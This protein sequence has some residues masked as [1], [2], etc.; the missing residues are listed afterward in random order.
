[1]KR[2]LIVLGL[3]AAHNAHAQSVRMQLTGGE[4]YAGLPFGLAIVADG[5]DE[6]PQPAQPTLAIPGATVTPLGVQPN[7]ST[8][9]QIF[10]GRRTETHT[11]RFVFQYRVQVDKAGE[12]QVPPV[13]IEQGSKKAT[14]DA[15]RLRVGDVP[16][17]DE[18]KLEVHVPDR[19]LWVGETFPLEIDWLVRKSPEDQQFSIP[20]FADDKTFQVVAPPNTNPRQAVPFPAG[21]HDV[22]LPFDRDQQGSYTRFKFTALVTPRQPGHLELPPAQVVARLQ[23]GD[24][25]FFGRSDS[26]LFKAADVAR[27]IDVKPLPLAN[28]PSSFAGAVGANFSIATR[29][30]RSV[31]QLGEPVDLEVTIKSDARLDTLSLGALGLPADKFSVPPDPPAGVLADDGKTKTFKVSV[32]VVGPA[33]EIPALAFSYFD[34]FKAEYATIHS[35][36]IA[37]SVKGTSI[38]GAA[39]VVGAPKKA[40][41]PKASETDDVSLVGADL[42]LSAP[43][44]ALATPLGGTTLWALVLI[45]Y[46]APIAIFG[47]RTWQ[48]RTQTEREEAGEVRAARRRV[49][50]E[51]AR[52][53]TAP[54]RDLATALPQALRA[55]AKAL[56]RSAQDDGGLIAKIET[57]AFAPGAADH[58]LPASLRAD[59]DAL[60]RRWLDERR[61]I[62]RA[63]IAGAI[64]LAI[65]WPARAHADASASIDEARA[66]YQNAM[67]ATQPAQRQQ[68]FARAQSAF[69]A[70]VDERPDAVDLLIDWGN[71]ALG[72]GDLGT[73]TLA[74]RR[75]L[76]VEPG[77]S[78][79]AR[80]LAWL[81]GRVPASMRPAEGGAAETL[82]FFHKT[83]PRAR[84]LVVGAAA[85]AIALILLTPWSGRRR[86][87][88]IIVAIAPAAIWLMMIV[89]IAL[90][91]GHGDDAVVVE[92]TVLRSA[93]SANAPQAQSAPVP[94]GAEVTVLE[95]RGGWTDVAFANGATGWLPDGAVQLVSRR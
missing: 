45:L 19:A 23:T 11:V 70:A 57:E 35:E 34:P 22:T 53:S 78:R 27:S 76:A 26:Q 82:F 51:L 93:D 46:L 52:A 36:P 69:A 38:V 1:M 56:G 28:R 10:N 71:A 64:L 37:L 9:I 60:V 59:A 39:D 75:A 6:N 50:D 66:A 43:G 21:A 67:A 5:F 17:T 84:K 3:L 30:S 32:Q 95:R 31:V 25:D 42:A 29:A 88:Q 86:R 24:A 62:P 55:L 16:T 81:R 33:T 47:V 65:A 12:Y 87:W 4:A 41:S 15:A 73:A 20:L 83:W 61:K 80:N 58:P 14:T 89:S 63:M 13:T 92:A 18:M 74:Y 2:A 40:S 91:R 48:V 94:A 49:E 77:A 54:A 72:A 44:D 85:F 68:A 8:S 90:E 79:A 7:V